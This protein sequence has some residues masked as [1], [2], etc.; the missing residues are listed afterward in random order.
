MVNI[1]KKMS[2]RQQTGFTLI[3]IMIVVAIIGVLTAI[4]LPSYREQVAKGNRAQAKAVLTQAQ[5]WME[6]F[7]SENY[8]YDK[9]LADVAVDDASLFGAQFST[10]PP[11]GEG[12]PAYAI[13]ISGT[14]TS[15]TYTITATV[16]GNMV[17]DKCGNFRITQTGRKSVASYSATAY[18]SALEAAR[19]CW[20]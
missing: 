8:R 12:R 5:Q 10:A 9:N 1:M 19:E 17:G 11:A 14:T 6:R 4:A 3:E 7:Y 15:R 13:S 20:R 18:S 16:T 2:K